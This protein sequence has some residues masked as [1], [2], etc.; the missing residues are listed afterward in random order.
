VWAWLLCALLFW[1]TVNPPQCDLCNG[2][3]FTVAS[4][5]QSTLK[6]SHPVAPDTCNGICSCC[7]FHS[8][9][10]AGQAR[11]PLNVAHAGVAAETPR[12]AFVPHA[13][14]FRPP[15]ILS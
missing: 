15:R 3:S 9:P 5:Q 7:G 11:L 14:I 10:N 6:H 12:P 4:A 1:L 8:L 2:G 13:A